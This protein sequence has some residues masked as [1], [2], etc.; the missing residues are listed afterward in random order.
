[1]GKKTSLKTIR[2]IFMMLLSFLFFMTGFSVSDI[3]HTK[4]VSKKKA[5][6]PYIRIN[7]HK[8]QNNQDEIPAYLIIEENDEV[9]NEI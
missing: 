2:A 1:M 3:W 6:I 8:Q 5:S 4:S 7:P 9:G